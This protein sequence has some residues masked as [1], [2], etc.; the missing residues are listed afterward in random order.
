MLAAALFLLGVGLGRWLPGGEPT[1]AGNA[2]V[3]AP[4]TQA[5][6]GK[7]AV[8]PTVPVRFVFAAPEATTVTVAG[9]WNDWKPDAAPMT[10]GAAGVFYTEVE[11]PP[12][13]YE[14]LFV[15]D[16]QRWTTD[17]AAPL[18]RDDGFGQKNSVLNI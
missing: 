7:V 9:S 11:L 8:P 1:P 4:P 12:G 5:A 6:A 3:A 13:Q 2:T 17:P 15:V 14:Y 18:A 10:R 16:G